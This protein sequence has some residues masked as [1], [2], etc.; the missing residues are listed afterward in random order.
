ML[1]K[2]PASRLRLIATIVQA[3][4]RRLPQRERALAAAFLR[5][6][7]RGVADEDLRARGSDDLAGAALTQLAGARRRRPGRPWVRVFN[8]DPARDGFR[9]SH[10]VVMIV[11]EDMPFLVDSMSMAVNQAGLAV[12]LIVHPVIDALRDRAGQL[13]AVPEP[14]TRG[15]RAES[16]QLLEIDRET[17]PHRLAALAAQIRA[18]LD[19]VQVAVADW[20]KMRER[21]QTLADRIESEPPPLPPAEALEGRALLEWMIDNHF[22]FLGARYYRLERGRSADRLVPDP[23][24]G[25]GLLRA[26]RPGHPPHLVHLSGAV[27][28]YA[29]SRSLLVITKANSVATVHRAT[30][31]DYVG[32]KT[33]DARGEVTGEH[34]FLGLWTSS[35]YSCSPRDIPALRHKVQEVIGHFGLAPQSHDGKAVLHVLEAHPRDEL[36]QATSAELIPIIRGIVNL[37]DRQRRAAVPAP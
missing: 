27:R 18:A 32:V 3:A 5:R 35:A 31:L 23:S 25:L 30:Y 1:G 2:V 20:P 33:F 13:T 24:S 12:H 17:D 15:A 28:K 16:W 11:C 26:G 37:Y 7:F 22:T 9:S 6:Y 8:P 21:A 4:R 19:D 29:R 14:G 36:F 10:T 34:R